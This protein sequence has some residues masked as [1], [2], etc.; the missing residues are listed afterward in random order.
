VPEKISL[1]K[2]GLRR[3]IDSTSLLYDSWRRDQG[4]LDAEERRRLDRRLTAAWL[5]ALLKGVCAFP[6][7]LCRLVHHLVALY[8]ELEELHFSQM[9]KMPR[10]KGCVIDRQTWLI[11][12]QNIRLGDYVKL[13]AYSSLMAGDRS[14]ITIGTNTII[15]TGVVI[16]TFNH[17]F[18][19]REVPMRYQPW[20]DNDQGSIE[21]GENVWIGAHVVILPGSKI[22][23]GAIIGAGSMVRGEVPPYSTVTTRFETRITAR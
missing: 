17:G 5:I 23:T 19:D 1:S 14:T 16:V 21:I 12:G 6:R 20:V 22:G 10:G 8:R 18:S 9:R 13:S 11:N 7:S 2:A 4:R 3:W 15:S